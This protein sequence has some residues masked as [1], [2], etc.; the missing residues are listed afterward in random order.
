MSLSVGRVGRVSSSGVSSVSTRD[1]A[2]AIG[3]RSQVSDVFTE[4]M[5]GIDQVQDVGLV[6]PVKYATAARSQAMASKAAN[7]G[8]N[9][10][11]DTFAYAGYDSAGGSYSYAQVG[12]NF[13][14]FV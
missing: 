4:R 3:N 7:A 12:K 2:Y 10:L 8:Y 13:D 6:E 14:E 9:D 5:A 1:Y 11:A